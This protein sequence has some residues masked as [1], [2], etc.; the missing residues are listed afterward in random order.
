MLQL[1]YMNAHEIKNNLL[2]T[3]V[4]LR[5]NGQVDRKNI[6]NLMKNLKNN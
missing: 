6:V 3:R 4:Y 1:M 2:V 5:F